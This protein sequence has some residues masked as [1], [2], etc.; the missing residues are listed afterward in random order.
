MSIIDVLE[1]NKRLRDNYIKNL[2][3]YL[4]R[5]KEVVRNIDPNTKIILFGSYVRGNFRPDSDIDVLIITNVSNEFDRLKIY[6][7]VNKAIGNPNPFE[8]HVINEEEYISWYSK[9]LDVYKEV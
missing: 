6:H 2:N 3:F 8:I 7:E 4:D 9:F 5:I 1:E